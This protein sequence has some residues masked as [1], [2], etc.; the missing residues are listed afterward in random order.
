MDGAKLGFTKVPQAMMKELG[1]SN[2]H[3]GIQ[4]C[5]IAGV[6]LLQYSIMMYLL[7]PK[8]IEKNKVDLKELERIA[9]E[10]KRKRKHRKNKE[11]EES[12][13]E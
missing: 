13:K 4:T 1:L 7:Q 10:K 11:S 6:L 5:I 9:E 2:F 12:S 8:Q 3:W